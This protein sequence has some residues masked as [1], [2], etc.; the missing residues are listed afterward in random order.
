MG[1][2]SAVLLRVGSASLEGS[3]EKGGSVADGMAMRL[4]M[5]GHPMSPLYWTDVKNWLYEILSG[6]SATLCIAGVPGRQ[7]GGRK[8]EKSE[9]TDNT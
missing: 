3:W 4:M 2:T 9:I 1:L 8:S 6:Q 7:Y 5:Q